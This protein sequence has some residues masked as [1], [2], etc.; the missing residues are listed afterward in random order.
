MRS[1]KKSPV[2]LTNDNWVGYAQNWIYDQEV[3][4]MEKTVSSP[5]WTGLTVFTIGTKGQERR[6]TKQ[7]LMHEKMFSADVRTAFKGQIFSAPMD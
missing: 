3:T 5:H 4:W 1:N 7:H 2:G 6:K